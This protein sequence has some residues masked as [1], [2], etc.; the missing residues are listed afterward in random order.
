MN[1][2]DTSSTWALKHHKEDLRFYDDSRETI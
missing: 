2:D 1:L